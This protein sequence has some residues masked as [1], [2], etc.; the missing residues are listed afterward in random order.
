[1]LGIR[2]STV[3]GSEIRRAPVDMV[4][5]TIIYRVLYISGGAGFL[6]VPYYVR[7]FVVSFDDI[8][9]VSS[10]I[11]LG[12]FVTTSAEVTLNGGLVRVPSPKIPKIQ[13]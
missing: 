13:V 8:I 11:F 9:Q 3:D 2:G 4:N 12:K 1:M 6:L 7:I 10:F 5:I